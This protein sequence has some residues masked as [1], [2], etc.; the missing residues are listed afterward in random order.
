MNVI[1]LGCI[2]TASIKCFTQDILAAFTLQQNTSVGPSKW[3]VL[4][5]CIGVRKCIVWGP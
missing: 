5:Y 2:H 1:F 4:E 3:V